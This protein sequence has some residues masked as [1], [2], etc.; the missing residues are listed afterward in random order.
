MATL[1]VRGLKKL[2]GAQTAVD[3][4]SHLFA[5]GEITAVVGPS[6]SGKTTTLWMIAGLTAPD[7]GAVLI[8]GI[9][10]TSRRAEQREIGMVFQSYA[11][12]PHLSVREN[13]EFGLRV[14][15]LEKGARRSRALEAL[16]LVRMDAFADRRVTSL[17]GGEQQRVALARALAFRPRVLLMDEPLSALDARLREDVRLELAQLLSTVKITTVYVTHDQTEAMALGARL[18][19]LESGRVAQAGSPAE[20]YRRPATPFVADFLGAAN[21]LE[22][23]CGSGEPRLLTLPFAELELPRDTAPGPCRVMIRPEDLVLTTNG[24]A[25]F[26]ANVVSSLFLGRQLRLV[27]EVG[28]QRL[29]MDA[30]P[31][32]VFYPRAEIGVRIRPDRVVVFPAGPQPNPGRMN[33]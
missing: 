17:S 20:V 14:R 9:D 23:V 30:S 27:L 10:V 22:G 2:F 7:A 29:V 15:G 25:Q 16:Q 3:D 28:E 8:D 31:D 12:F 11:L 5:D 18:L 1:E 32:T 19:V 13:V 24:S 6:G 26:H 33:R 4:I 21:L